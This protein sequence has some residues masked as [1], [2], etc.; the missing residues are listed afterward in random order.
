LAYLLSGNKDFVIDGQKFSTVEE[1]IGY[2]NQ[3]LENSADT[4]EKFCYKLIDSDNNLNEEFEAWL[5]AIG[6]RAE[7]NTWKNNLKNA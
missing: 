4:F 6:K 2:M 7:L 5:I 1:L 3:L